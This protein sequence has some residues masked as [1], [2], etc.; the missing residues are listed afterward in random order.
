MKAIYSHLLTFLTLFL[1]PVFMNAAITVPITT[2]NCTC[3]GICNG[4]ATAT[5]AGGTAPYTFSWSAGGFTTSIAPNLCAGTYTC[6]VTDAAGG[7]AAVTFTITAPAALAVTIT[8]VNTSCFS[9]T[10][11]ATASASGGTAPFTYSWS[12][13]PGAGQGTASASGL[14]AGTY[15]LTLTDKNNCTQTA[16]GIVNTPNPPTASITNAM[17]VFCFG[18][19]TGSAT[20]GATGGLSPYTYSW[21][22]SGGTANKATGLCAGTYTVNVSDHNGC[23]AS[24]VQNISQNAALAATASTTSATCS[25]CSDG[26]A[27]LTASQGNSPYTYS[28]HPSGATSMTATGLLPGTYTCCVTDAAA[29]QICDYSITVAY[30]TGIAVYQ[31]DAFF[32]AYPNPFGNSLTLVLASELQEGELSMYDL[33]GRLVFHT[34]ISAGTTA[35]ST[36]DLPVG[37][38]FLFL[39]AGQNRYLKKIVRE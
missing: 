25:T 18:A 36:A 7:S 1:L 9:P 29:C 14:A 23:R 3:S 35:I 19:C 32:N 5:P 38:Y 28:W 16:I 2:V 37:M 26:S 20:V 10:G 22:P 34:K 13:T 21:S 24:C 11:T 33:P 8:T 12:P 17:N 39:N 30:S 27:T 4:S 31:N 6:G 15:T